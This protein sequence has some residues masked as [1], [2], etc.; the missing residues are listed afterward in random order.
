[1]YVCMYFFY[2]NR[3]IR[4]NLRKTYNCCC[5][6]DSSWHYKYFCYFIRRDREIKSYSMS[7]REIC[8]ISRQLFYKR[9]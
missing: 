2:V 3:L 6:L 1:M 5:V 9:V 7:V 8:E 4:K